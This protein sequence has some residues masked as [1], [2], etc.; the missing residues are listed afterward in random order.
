M[1]SSF[2]VTLAPIELNIR[3]QSLAVSTAGSRRVGLFSGMPN[4]ISTCLK[5]VVFHFYGHLFENRGLKL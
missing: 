1:E 2:T 3:I 4:A 5:T